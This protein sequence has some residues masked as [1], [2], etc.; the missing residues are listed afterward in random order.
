MKGLT[1]A[2]FVFGIYIC[3]C[4]CPLAPNSF[5]LIYKLQLISGADPENFSRGDPN[6]RPLISTREKK[7]KG[8]F[9]SDMGLFF[10][11]LFVC[12]SLFFFFNIV[13]EQ[14]GRCG[15]GG[16]GGPPPEKFE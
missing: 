10:M 2:V 16:S 9:R 12:P 15:G 6:L 13:S 11:Q 8:L 14:C 5:P 4:I 1:L 7:G 3:P